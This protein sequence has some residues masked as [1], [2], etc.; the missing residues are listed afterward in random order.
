MTQIKCKRCK[1]LVDAVDTF[2]RTCIDCIK[3]EIPSNKERKG[4]RIR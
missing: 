2:D 3:R 4:R 1:R